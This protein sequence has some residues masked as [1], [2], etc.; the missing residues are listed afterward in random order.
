MLD[1]FTIAIVTTARNQRV[2][3]NANHLIIKIVKYILIKILKD[4]F[5]DSTIDEMLLLIAY[6]QLK[7]LQEEIKMY[8]E[9]SK[10][11]VY[12]LYSLNLHQIKTL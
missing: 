11:T 1:D 4:N 5:V 8:E 7:Y 6:S 12:I 10:A 9:Q 3:K 2:G